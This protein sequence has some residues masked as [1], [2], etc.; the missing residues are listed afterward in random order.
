MPDNGR[1][2]EAH[3]SETNLADNDRITGRRDSTLISR[4]TGHRRSRECDG[5]PTV[6]L[7]RERGG[8]LLRPVL[9]VWLE[10]VRALNFALFKHCIALSLQFD[11]TKMYE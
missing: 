5:S 8:V 10:L 9:I 2:Y 1:V 6:S 4:P 11:P 7:C 3:K